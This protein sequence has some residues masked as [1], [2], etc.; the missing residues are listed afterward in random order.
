M[1]LAPRIRVYGADN[2]LDRLPCTAPGVWR[3]HYSIPSGRR[4]YC[5]AR[6]ATRSI[7]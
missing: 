3:Q 7:L 1:L 2:V 4:S 5:K 6:A